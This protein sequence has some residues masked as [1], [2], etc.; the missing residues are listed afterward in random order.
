MA[1]L[2]EGSMMISIK[3]IGHKLTLI[4]INDELMSTALDLRAYIAHSRKWHANDFRLLYQGREVMN[5]ESLEKIINRQS[6]TLA[7]KTPFVFWALMKCNPPSNATVLLN[8]N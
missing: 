2:D 6:C 5:N 7:Q 4:S 3:T 8:I 1:S